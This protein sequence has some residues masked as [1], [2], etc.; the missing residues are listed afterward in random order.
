MKIYYCDII[1]NLNE[2]NLNER[3]FKFLKINIINP[4]K[5]KVKQVS[6]EIGNLV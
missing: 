2:T 4:K 3:I 5:S 1:V 6:V